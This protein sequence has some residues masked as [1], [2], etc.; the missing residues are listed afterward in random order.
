MDTY[1]I[2]RDRNGN[3]ICRVKPAEGRGFTIQTNGNLIRTHRDGIGPWTQ[4][5][6][7]AYVRAYGTKTQRE[8]L[9]LK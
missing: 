4:G 5:E 3:R 2:G 8:K 1:E 6:V 7:S 9:N